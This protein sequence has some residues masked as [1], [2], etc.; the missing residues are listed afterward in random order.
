[1]EINGPGAVGGSS[2]VSQ[3]RPVQQPQDPGSQAPRPSETDE[4][5]IS[6]MG[7]LL[8]DLSGHSEIR[9]ERVA[10]V[11]RAIE[12]GT[13]ETPEKLNLA[14]EKLLDEFRQQ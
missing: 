13:Y 12:A 8:D 5:E 11:R 1:M 10:E 6:E 2:P 4:V 14:V 9:K 3:P 7:R